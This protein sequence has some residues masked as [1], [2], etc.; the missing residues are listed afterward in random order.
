M[1]K[2]TKIVPTNAIVDSEVD[3]NQASL[4][5]LVNKSNRVL[6]TVKTVFP[7]DFFPDTIVVDENKT[8]VIRR[9]FFAS[10]AVYTIF[11]EN[12]ESITVTNSLFLAAVRVDARALH[13]IS[14]TIKNLKKDDAARVKRIITGLV[15][16]RKEKIN[17]ARFSAA[18]LTYK[19]EEIGRMHQN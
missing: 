17:T 12:I 13:E 15:I 2:V 5:E 9:F 1:I 11:I 3:N 8:T 4:D 18:E 6:L 14:R 16:C 19:I 10:Q 7:F